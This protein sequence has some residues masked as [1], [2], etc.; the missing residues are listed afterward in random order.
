MSEGTIKQETG[1]WEWERFW[2][3][4]SSPLWQ[5]AL[6]LPLNLHSFPHLWCWRIGHDQKNRIIDTSRWSGFPQEGGL[7]TNSHFPRLCVRF[8]MPE[9]KIVIHP[10][11]WGSARVSGCLQT[12]NA[13]SMFRPLRWFKHLVKMLRGC[14]PK[15]VFQG[16][17]CWEKA[18]GQVQVERL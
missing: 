3:R 17:S 14:L 2:A 13:E 1:W 6:D 18:P 7:K 16:M 10:C 4:F 12:H 11:P 8:G 9:V 5:E 15:E